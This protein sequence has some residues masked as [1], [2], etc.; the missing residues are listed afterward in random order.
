M[1]V[2]QRLLDAAVDQMERRWPA[3]EQAG[4][5]AVYLSDGSILTSVCLDNI[6]PGVVLCHEV[7]ALCQAYTQ[8]AIVVASGCA[9]RDEGSAQL[10]VYAP[11]GVCQE[12]LALWVPDVQVGVSD[13]ASASGWSSRSLRDVNPHYWAARFGSDGGWPSLTQHTS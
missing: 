7:G 10:H 8:N 4:A 5:A 2:D 12:R 6:N 1:D 3:G 13:P 9:G 11:C